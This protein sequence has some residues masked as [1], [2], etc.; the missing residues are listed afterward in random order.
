M[1]SRKLFTG[2]AG[3][4]PAEALLGG[5]NEK[6]DTSASGRGKRDACGPSEELARFGRTIELKGS[7]S[8]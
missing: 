1:E 4:P 6:Q 3:V 5:M 8:K 2:T 7:D